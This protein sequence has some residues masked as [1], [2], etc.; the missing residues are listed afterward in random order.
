MAIWKETEM[1]LE[2]VEMKDWS[3]QRPTFSL[4]SVTLSSKP[5]SNSTAHSAITELGMEKRMEAE[6][7]MLHLGEWGDDTT[8]LFFKVV[9]FETAENLS[10]PS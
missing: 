6:Q 7:N 2:D 9:K 8:T 10:F 1:W 5:R 4:V 3:D